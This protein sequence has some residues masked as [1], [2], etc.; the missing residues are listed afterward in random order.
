MTA[1]APVFNKSR[2]WAVAITNVLGCVGVGLMSYKGMT[3]LNLVIVYFGIDYTTYGGIAGIMFLFAL[4]TAL[5]AGAIVAKLGASRLAKICLI[6]IFIGTI[7]PTILLLACGRATNYLLMSCLGIPCMLGWGAMTV[8]NT[9]LVSDWFPPTKRP[10]PMA[11]N[12]MFTP[13]AMLAVLFL[14][15][16]LINMASTEGYTEAELTMTFGQSPYGVVT[17]TVA[18]TIYV[19]IVTI[20]AMF[21]I[22]NP[23][24]ENSFIGVNSANE[25]AGVAEQVSS[26]A[27]RAREGYTNLGI[28]ILIIMF[29][30]Y[31][32]G[33]NCFANYWPTYVE[34]DVSMGGFN[35]PPQ[36]ANM[37][38]TIVAFTEIVAGIIVGW[39]LTKV[40]HDRWWLIIL[41]VAL[42]VAVNNVLEFQVP[43][44][45][46][47]VPILILY[48]CTQEMWPPITFT[49][50]PELL[51]SPK[52]LGNAL[53][54]MS[55]INNLS[56]T[57]ISTTNGII[58]DNWVNVPGGTWNA[59]GVPLGISAAV[60]AIMA[61]L[62][63]W[64]WRKRWNVLK[65]RAAE[66][67]AAQQAAAAQAD[68]AAAAV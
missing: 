50:A 24:P 41:I 61:I 10:L 34:S 7:C 43:S 56:G 35:I 8:A 28:R 33:A 66:K 16:P 63:V 53:G 15:T 3:T 48:G 4:A 27:G 19:T 46:W 67:L 31:T 22:K 6:L 55:F 39:G 14:S 21:I 23:K 37:I 1:T 62:I 49:L 30:C 2:A 68:T 17:V 11:I 47:F 64:Y 36:D 9:M 42:A 52:A 59:F 65:A 57:I 45:G 20:F 18:F 5:P 26:D 13:V 54:L 32:W 38:S 29:F 58:A 12:S 60:M 51:D 40:N 25:E 44:A